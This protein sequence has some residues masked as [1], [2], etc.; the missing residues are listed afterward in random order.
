MNGSPSLSFPDECLT[1]EM[2]TSRDWGRE[3]EQQFKVFDKK[4]APGPNTV[5]KHNWCDD[6]S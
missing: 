3:E 2:G 5:G 6:K 1:F 4:V